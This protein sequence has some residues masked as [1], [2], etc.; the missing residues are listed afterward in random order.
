MR[1][2]TAIALLVLPLT[3]CWAAPARANINDDYILRNYGIVIG[4][5]G[6]QSSQWVNSPTRVF[7]QVIVNGSRRNYYFDSLPAALFVLRERFNRPQVVVLDVAEYGYASHPSEYYDSFGLIDGLDAYYVWD[8]NNFSIGGV[9][10]VLAFSDL[11]DAQDELQ[12]RDGRVMSFDELMDATYRWFDAERDRVYWRGWDARYWNDRR[13]T[14]AWRHR[15]NGYDWDDDYGWIALGINLDLSRLGQ[16]HHRRWYENDRMRTFQFGE[17]YRTPSFH[18]EG[19]STAPAPVA[20]SR[21]QGNTGT[22]RMIVLPPPPKATAP[23]KRAVQ[24]APPPLPPARANQGK[25]AKPQPVKPGTAVP[26]PVP[27]E[28][29]SRNVAPQKSV[30]PPPPPSAKRGNI[31]PPKGV[32]PPPPNPR[33]KN[34]VPPKGVTPPPPPPA[35]EP[36]GNGKVLPPPRRILVPVPQGNGNGNGQGAGRGSG[37]RR[38]A[39]GAQG[40]AKGGGTKPDNRNRHKQK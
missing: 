37:V 28:R 29:K 12:Y 39:G 14:S 16:R 32:T 30:A 20:P 38:S 24:P 13:W 7:A 8:Y 26:A 5:M 9:P 3:L 18:A 15:W 11:Q 25:S 34:I 2:I 1:F 6:S 21:V 27:P 23:P 36:K 17:A 33:R 35:R 40:N 19:G 22:R 4:D 10:L 31:I